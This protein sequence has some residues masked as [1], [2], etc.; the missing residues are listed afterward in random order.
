[1]RGWMARDF[2]RW[3]LMLPLGEDTETH[4]PFSGDLG[5]NYVGDSPL[6][7]PLADNGGPTL[8]E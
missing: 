7:G 4:W 5:G 1:M 8:T 2:W 6:L 3:A